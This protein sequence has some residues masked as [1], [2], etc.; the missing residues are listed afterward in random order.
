MFTN[1]SSGRIIGKTNLNLEESEISI[2]IANKCFDGKSTLKTNFPD[3]FPSLLF[4]D[5]LNKKELKA[6]FDH[7]KKIVLLKVV[8]Y[9][10]I[11]IQTIY[12]YLIIR[13]IR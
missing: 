8:I 3:N 4:H 9:E 11:I 6:E 7:E 10:Y 1:N 5:D 2:E 13:F 12:L